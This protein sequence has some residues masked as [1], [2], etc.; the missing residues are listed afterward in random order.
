MKKLIASEFQRIWLNKKTKILLMLIV[1]DTIINCVFRLMCPSGSYN[2]V[3]YNVVLNSLNFSPF[4][5]Y[6]ARLVLLYIAL[7]IIFIDSMNYEQ[8][9]GAFRMYMIRPYKKY[10]FIISKWIALAL[11]TFILMFIVFI[12]STVFGYL[13][14]SKVLTVKFYNIQYSFNAVAALLYIMKF[15]MIQ[16]LIAVFIL[17]ITAV[18]AIL[19]PNSII[20]ILVVIASTAALGLFTKT[21][22]F[23]WQTTKYGFY[24]LVHTAPVSMHLIIA[25][26][27]IGGLFIGMG[28]W[29]KKDY[30][31]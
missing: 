7:P 5:F 28:L 22:E 23:L 1:I 26:G 30:L 4:V 17:S 31:C 3:D 12:I 16:F 10:E 19:I 20:S 24:T 14:M 29:M 18:I 13:F 6:E 9:V 15:Y 8:T 2:G 21:F 27:I 25:V 11:T